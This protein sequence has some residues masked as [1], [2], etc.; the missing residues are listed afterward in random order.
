M[1]HVAVK[2]CG[3]STPET[4]EAAIKAGAD[5]A[6][7]VFYEKSPRHIDL[8]AASRLGEIA[9][10]RIQ[11]VALSVD[12]DDDAL[13]AM[14]DAL[15]PDF[16]QLHGNETP[17]R[18]AA[19]RARFRRKIIKAIGVATAT[20]VERGA[21]YRAAD[22]LIYDAKPL[23]DAALPGGNGVV[24]DWRLMRGAA[25]EKPWL[26]SGGL[27]ASNVVEALRVSGARGVDVS[28]GVERSRGVKDPARIAAFVGA[29]RRSGLGK[30][31]SP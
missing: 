20:D 21:A 12:A 14:I 7:F 4:L 10:G 6:G 9:A 1:S 23:P 24:F 3:L 15:A 22:M 18:V 29:A 19:V 30:P 11:K 2:I 5:M 27:D 25:A 31:K 8:A 17:E 26:L 28:S 16:L 13:A